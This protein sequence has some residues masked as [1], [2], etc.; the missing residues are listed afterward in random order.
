M[1]LLQA[2]RTRL[3]SLPAVTALVG[4]RISVMMAQQ[5]P[6]SRSVLLQEIS[7]IDFAHLRGA[8]DLMPS[9]IQVDVFVTKGDGD[10]YTDA[11]L[12]SGTIRGDF[13][14]GVATGLVGFQGLVGDVYIQAIQGA[15]QREIFDPEEM[16]VVRVLSEYFVWFHH[17]AA[18][19]LSI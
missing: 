2:I 8:T 6:A 9:R 7:R 3:L 11:H 1:T 13:T 10:A 17:T 18:S 4:N 14:G 16:Q 19:G 15:G 12:I 5:S